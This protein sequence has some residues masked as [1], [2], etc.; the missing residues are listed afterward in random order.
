MVYYRNNQDETQTDFSDF[1]D[2]CDQCG[3]LLPKETYVEIK[4]SPVIIK[5][6]R[7]QR[8]SKKRRK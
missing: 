5:L 8:R 7:K 2:K 3:Q 6:N 1:G 4:P